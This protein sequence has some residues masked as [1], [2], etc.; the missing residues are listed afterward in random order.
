MFA[1]VALAARSTRLD[2]GCGEMLVGRAL[3]PRSRSP[4]L[5]PLAGALVRPSCPNRTYV[6]GVH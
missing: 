3:T 6:C 5:L 4:R 1:P 2:P